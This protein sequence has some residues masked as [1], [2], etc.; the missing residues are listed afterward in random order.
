MPYYDSPG[1]DNLVYL[2]VLLQMLL[3][4]C[5]LTI[6]AEIIYIRNKTFWHNTP[7]LGFY[8]LTV[9]TQYLPNSVLPFIDC[10]YH[11]SVQRG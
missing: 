1:F 5:T 11:K 10:G 2:F 7:A 9:P 6:F 8:R 3:V 4:S